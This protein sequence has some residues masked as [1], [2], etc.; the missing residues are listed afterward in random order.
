LNDSD[1]AALEAAV[2]AEVAEAVA[3]AESGSWEPVEDLLKD[4]QTPKEGRY[5]ERPT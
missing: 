2:A 1:L 3:F 4:V 5:H